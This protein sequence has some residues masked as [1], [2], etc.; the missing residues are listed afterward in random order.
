MRKKIF[1]FFFAD[2]FPIFFSLLLLSFF[3]PFLFSLS[4]TLYPLSIQSFGLS[5]SKNLEMEQRSIRWLG[6][7]YHQLCTQNWTRFFGYS[8]ARIWSIFIID[9]RMDGSVL[10]VIAANQNNLV[11]SKMM[12]SQVAQWF[13]TWTSGKYDSW[14]ERVNG[15]QCVGAHLGWMTIVA[16]SRCSLVSSGTPSIQSLTLRQLERSQWLVSP[17]VSGCWRSRTT[18]R[19]TRSFNPNKGDV[20]RPRLLW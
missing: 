19:C 5:P 18:L 8:S 4:S 11:T 13:L 14:R 3:S 1:F 2:S 17:C 9:T 10:A 6:P 7:F 16:P 20:K 15:V 12:T